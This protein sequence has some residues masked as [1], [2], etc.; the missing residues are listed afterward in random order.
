[1]QAHQHDLLSEGQEGCHRQQGVN[2]HLPSASQHH[3]TGH[4]QKQ[5]GNRVDVAGVLV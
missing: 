4:Q 2:G 1:M 3:E 5:E